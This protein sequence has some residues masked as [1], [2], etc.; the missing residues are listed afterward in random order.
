[1]ANTWSV[2]DAIGSYQN[3]DETSTT[4]K[5]ALGTIVK[6]ESATYGVCEF[7][8]LKGVASTVVG[9]P[10]ICDSTL[11]TALISAGARGNVGVAM[12]ANVASQY[13]WYCIYGLAPIYCG[14]NAITS[15]S[16]LFYQASGTVDD[17]VS[18][19]N[20]IDGC[21]SKSVHGTPAANYCVAT[22]SR[23]SMNGNG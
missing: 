18:A 2:H 15:G 19:T 23:P 10:V 6:A 21:V 5:H 12:S 3:I 20:K 16:A 14:A 22:L 9:S 1:M 17:A 11:T 7:V 4:Q 13:G 8:Y